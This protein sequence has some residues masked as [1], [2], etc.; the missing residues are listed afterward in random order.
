MWMPQFACP[1]LPSHERR[2]FE[3]QFVVRW[4]R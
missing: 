2:A 3:R 1:Y 4:S